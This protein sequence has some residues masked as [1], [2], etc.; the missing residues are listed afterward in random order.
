MSLGNPVH[1]NPRQRYKEPVVCAEAAEVSGKL[2]VKEDKLLTCKF[3]GGRGE[4]TFLPHDSKYWI[5]SAHRLLLHRDAA[6][7]D[8]GMFQSKACGR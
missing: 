5:V 1:L 6:R 4:S 7:V 3:F 2:E 8:A